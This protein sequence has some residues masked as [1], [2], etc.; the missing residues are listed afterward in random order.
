MHSGSGIGSGGVNAKGHTATFHYIAHTERM[1]FA[2]KQHRGALNN[3]IDLTDDS[4]KFKVKMRRKIDS[5]EM[6]KLCERN[7]IQARKQSCFH[8][9]KAIE[10]F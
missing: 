4:M 10:I 1:M 7:T 5:I 6:K 2:Q 3:S 9:L 8:C